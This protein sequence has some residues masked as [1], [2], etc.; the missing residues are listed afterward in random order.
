[1]SQNVQYRCMV[2]DRAQ[3]KFIN[4]F[5]AITM[6]VAERDFRNACNDPNTYLHKN[7]KDYALWC[8][9]ETDFVTGRTKDFEDPIKLLEADQCITDRKPSQ[10][11]EEVAK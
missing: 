2:K 1:M 6:G 9:G 10:P 11:I 7:S 3:E 4:C 8:I 5:H